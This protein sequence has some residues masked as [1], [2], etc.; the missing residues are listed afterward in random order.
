MPF[1]RASLSEEGSRLQWAGVTSKEDPRHPQHG[2]PSQ[3]SDCLWLVAKYLNGRE[4]ADTLL[5]KRRWGERPGKSLQL[6]TGFAERPGM[7]MGN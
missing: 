7:R 1:P 6:S 3:R 2:G 5:S 4:S